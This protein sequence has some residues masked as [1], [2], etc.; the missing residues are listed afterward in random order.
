M[1]HRRSHF[2]GAVSLAVMVAIT[3]IGSSLIVAQVDSPTNKTGKKSEAQVTN[4]VQENE[5]DVK[6]QPSSPGS[7]RTRRHD[8]SAEQNATDATAQ[9]GRQTRR[10]AREP[11]N[12]ERAWL[13]VL[14]QD[15]GDQPGALVANV[16][17]GS[18]AARAGFR[19][20]DV[21][22]EVNGQK[23]TSRDDLI[24]AID[25]LEPKSR[26]ELVV[27]RNGQDLTM[28]VVLGRRN[29]F[30]SR[31]D[32]YRDD[33]ESGYEDEFGNIPPYAMQM[34]HD[35][36]NAEQHQRIEAEIR[37]LQ[38]EIRQLRDVIQQRR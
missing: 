31:N 36:R 33:A 32:W 17:P 24:A 8:Q 23:V 28:P 30:V 2:I 12:E 1:S 38:D 18:P 35:R 5:T 10:S 7:A 3:A 11:D 20:G 37:K 14:L 4:R 16:Y 6:E 26:A 13:G 21:I 22:S 19:S 27:A 34:E 15:N 9:E 29:A 25:Q